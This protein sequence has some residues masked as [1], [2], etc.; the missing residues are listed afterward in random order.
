V[1]QFEMHH[2]AARFTREVA[3]VVPWV[4]I[5]QARDAERAS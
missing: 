1:E 4:G 5:A 2:V 3:K